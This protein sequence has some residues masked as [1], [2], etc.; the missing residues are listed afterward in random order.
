M[1]SST[2]LPSF[3]IRRIG[4]PPGEIHSE[5]HAEAEFEPMRVRMIRYSESDFHVDEIK[6]GC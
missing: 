1:L 3:R 5:H 2:Q 6:N 4:A